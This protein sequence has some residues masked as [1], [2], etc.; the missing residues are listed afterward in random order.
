M[1]LSL[2]INSNI[3]FILHRLV[4]VHPCQT[5]RR[6]TTMT[7]A[8]PLL[9]YGRLEIKNNFYAMHFNDFFFQCFDVS[10]LKKKINNT[11][12]CVLYILM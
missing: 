10:H 12:I 11:Q 2:V 7:T 3:S 9:K 4:T 8:R 1:R 5:D 6:T